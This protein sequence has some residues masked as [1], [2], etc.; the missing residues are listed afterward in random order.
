MPAI[1][2]PKCGKQAYE[3]VLFNYSAISCSHCGYR[4]EPRQNFVYTQED[5]RAD[6][7]L[8]DSIY[9]NHEDDIYYDRED[10]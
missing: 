10:Y 9:G 6:Q 7:D 4:S 8:L 1:G 2:C 5:F 3:N